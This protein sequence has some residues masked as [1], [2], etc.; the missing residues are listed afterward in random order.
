VTAG[1]IASAIAVA[2]AVAT[3]RETAPGLLRLTA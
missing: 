1:T 3:R 2:M